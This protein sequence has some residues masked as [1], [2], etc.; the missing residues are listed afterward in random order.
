MHATS[1]STWV[2][3]LAT[4]MRAAHLGAVPAAVLDRAAIQLFDALACASGAI[5]AEPVEI[6]RRVVKGSGPQEASALFL[7]ERLSLADAVLVN[8]SAIRYLDYNDAFIGTG[9]GGH[10]SD[11][12]AVALAVGEREGAS[13]R[14]VLSAIALGYELYW[15]L[16]QNVY[17]RTDKSA[18]WDGTS[19]SGI[20]SALIAGLLLDL[21]DEELTHALA[22]GAVRSYGLKEIRRGS[23]STLKACGNALVAREGTLAA[24]LAQQGM[25]GPNEVFEGRSGLLGAFGLTPTAEL[26]DLLVAPP[27]WVIENI[28]IKAYPAVATSQAA[29]HGAIQIAHELGAGDTIES[30][31]VLVP[32]SRATREHLAI[33]QRQRP[34]SRE[35][36]DHSVA[37][38]V[39]AALED[40][41]L[42]DAQFADE[43]WTR[44]STTR[45]MEQITIVPDADL[46]S[47]ADRCYPARVEVTLAS[48]LVRVA[49]ISTTPGS[50]GDPW[51]ANDVAAKFLQTQRFGMSSNAVELIRD[52][53]LAL[54]HAPDLARLMAAAAPVGERHGVRGSTG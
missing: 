52:E 11:N 2:A 22:I 53:I 27:A 5:D 33:K 44:P 51:D 26:H 39:A 34:D 38:L 24:L 1:V 13:G 4:A 50:P 25:G 35:S 48:G 23:I 19:V 17:A 6:A 10:P 21:D 31:S 32:E 16:R 42:T 43:R 3:D 8:G 49:D 46:A 7:P 47:R 14:D 45:L 15:R 40:G 36:A 18:D 54:P 29:I 30:V 37:F 28:S 20:V 41:E 12:I 9:P